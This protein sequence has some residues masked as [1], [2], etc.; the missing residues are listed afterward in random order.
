MTRAEKFAKHEKLIAGQP[1]EYPTH[2]FFWDDGQ[3]SVS[4]V[5]QENGAVDRNRATPDN[6]FDVVVFAE[7]I[8]DDV[9]RLV[10]GP[11][12]Q[13]NTVRWELEDGSAIIIKNENWRFGLSQDEIDKPEI[14]E[15]VAANID[16]EDRILFVD[17]E[18]LQELP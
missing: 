7:Y 13:L 17:R 18:T 12:R 15:R 5:L 11:E 9:G 14:K 6:T 1:H 8:L 2:E 16:R 10:W 4:T 3:F